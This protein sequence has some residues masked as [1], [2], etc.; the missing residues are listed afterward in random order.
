MARSLGAGDSASICKAAYRVDI[1]EILDDIE[2]SFKRMQS[3]RR[4]GGSGTRTPQAPAHTTITLEREKRIK[5]APISKEDSRRLDEIV[6]QGTTASVKI[7]GVNLLL[8]CVGNTITSM[9][10]GGR[11]LKGV[12]MSTE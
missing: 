10:K 1:D 2:D 8:T 11:C 6:R 5:E 4:S 12:S 3:L 9:Q 7:E